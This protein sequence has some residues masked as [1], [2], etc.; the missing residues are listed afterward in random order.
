MSDVTIAIA[1]GVSAHGKKN[2]K[3]YLDRNRVFVMNREICDPERLAMQYGYRCVNAVMKLEPSQTPERG[4]VGPSLLPGSENVRNALVETGS[5]SATTGL[6]SAIAMLLSLL[7]CGFIQ[8]ERKVENRFAAN[9]GFFVIIPDVDVEDMN[10]AVQLATLVVEV[11]KHSIEAALL[12]GYHYIDDTGLC[13]L[14][15]LVFCVI[16]TWFTRHPVLEA[17]RVAFDVQVATKHVKQTVVGIEGSILAGQLIVDGAVGGA[18]EVVDIGLCD[19]RTGKTDERAS[20]KAN[21]GKVG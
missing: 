2:T 3:V 10:R 21:G 1:V 4:H 17:L 13:A 16:Q 5:S 20:A 9:E 12:T 15:A 7:G 14:R 18:V 8:A 19:G 6:P 11:F